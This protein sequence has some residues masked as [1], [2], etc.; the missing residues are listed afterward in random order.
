MLCPLC[1]EKKATRNY[2]RM[3]MCGECLKSLCLFCSAKVDNIIFKRDCKGHEVAF[4]N[5]RNRFLDDP[6]FVR[7]SLMTSEE[8]D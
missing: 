1:N 6:A 4:D 7:E 2:Q 3:D 8:S 5:K